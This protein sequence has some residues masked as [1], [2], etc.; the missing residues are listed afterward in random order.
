MGKSSQ[1]THQ[2]TDHQS[3]V[4]ISSPPRQNAYSERAHVFRS[5]SLRRGRVQQVGNFHRDR[6]PNPFFK[7][8][9]PRRHLSIDLSGWAPFACTGLCGA[10][11]LP[12][13]TG[14]SD[15]T[16]LKL[17]GL[18]QIERWSPSGEIALTV[19]A[20]ARTWLGQLSPS[21]LRLTCYC[22]DRIGQ[23]RN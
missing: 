10:K 6:Q 23:H 21:I 12:E 4:Q 20:S 19:A 13:P 18:A 3:F 22:S 5:S 8:S 15:D 14:I 9:R 11:R 2:R 1:L 16:Y 17:M 7:S